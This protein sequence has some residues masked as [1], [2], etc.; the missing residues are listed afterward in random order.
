MLD[1]KTIGYKPKY[2]NPETKQ[3]SIDLLARTWDE[4]K[5][6]DLIN[7]I[8]V[9]EY[10]VARPDLISLAVYGSDMYGDLICKY[11]GISNPF[12]LN[13]GMILFIPPIRLATDMIKAREH[14]ATER[15]S[16]DAKETI[17]ERNKSQKMR[18]EV[19]SSSES[20]AGSKAPYVIDKT[21]GLVFY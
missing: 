21:L 13:E 1:Y 16:K 10:Y 3:D 17:R 18:D 6:E 11:N 2:K 15:I 20:V 9:N 7:P 5:D 19:H 8:V 4:F 12:E 14:N